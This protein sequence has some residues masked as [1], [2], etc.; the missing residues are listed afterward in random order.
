VADLVVKAS[1]LKGIEIAGELVPRA[2]DE[3]PVLC[4][5]AAVAEGTTVLRDAQELRVKETDRIAAMAANLRLAGVAVTETGDGM[6]I[7]GREK[8]TAFQ[9]DSRGDHRIAMAM[10]IA[11]LL[12]DGPSTVHDIDC[13]ATSFPTFL[14]LLEQVAVR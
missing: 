12:A 4:V 9:A 6:V 1:R 2:I 5:A 8:L 3:F 7:A 13:I 14:T 10:L 11:G